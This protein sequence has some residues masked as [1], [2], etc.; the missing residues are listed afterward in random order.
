MA[1]DRITGVNTV[2]VVEARRGLHG[3]GV[4]APAGR[5]MH[6]P[7]RREPY[8]RAQEPRFGTADAKAAAWTRTQILLHWVD[9]DGKAR[10]EWVLATRV[11][12]ISR[13]DSSWKDPYD[14]EW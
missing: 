1:G 6:A 8:V 11:R 5:V 3:P 9:E 4:R 14:T 10:N 12:R 7:Y 13:A 2:D